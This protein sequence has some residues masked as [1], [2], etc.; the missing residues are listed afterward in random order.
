VSVRRALLSERPKYGLRLRQEFEAGPGEVYMTL[1]RLER[2]GL[3][4]SGGAGDDG[5]QKAFRNTE[6]GAAELDEWLRTPS[7][8][9]S[10]PRDEL[11]MCI[12][13]RIPGLWAPRLPG[14][15]RRAAVRAI[16]VHLPQ[17]PLASGRFSE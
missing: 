5:P 12:R 3:V 9:T 17:D 1:Q 8:M 16:G 4:E 7:D 13:P 6:A 2:D 10:P 15:P 14:T 11:L